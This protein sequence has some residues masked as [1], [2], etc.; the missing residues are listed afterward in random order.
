M[1]PRTAGV[2]VSAKIGDPWIISKDRHFRP[3]HPGRG[4]PPVHGRRSLQRLECAVLVAE[5]GINQHLARR[6]V[7]MFRRQCLR[8]IAPA[9]DG[10][11]VAKVSPVTLRDAVLEQGNRLV[12]PSGKQQ[13][14]AKENFGIGNFGS[15][16]RTHLA[17][18]IA[19]A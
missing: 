1:R 17:L 5:T 4:P 14:P 2:P 12:R 9:G 19:S 3:D 7:R 18:S 8:L 10:I 16:S 13:R 11:Q 6:G 15:R